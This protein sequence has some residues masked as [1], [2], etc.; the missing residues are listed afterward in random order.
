MIHY[1]MTG[2]QFLPYD[3]S[4]GSS[5]F[6]TIYYELNNCTKNATNI[7]RDCTLRSYYGPLCYNG[8]NDVIL[9]CVRE[10]GKINSNINFIV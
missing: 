9:R 3:S 1:F 2:G 8:S 10:P 4:Y 6:G 7:T 5:P